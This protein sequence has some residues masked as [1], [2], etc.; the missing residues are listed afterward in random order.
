MKTLNPITMI[1][2]TLALSFL[3]MPIPTLWAEGE[4]TAP[5]APRQP[6]MPQVPV[7]PTQQPPAP[8]LPSAVPGNQP[9]DSLAAPAPIEPVDT[10]SDSAEQSNASAPESAIEEP[11]SEASPEE[12]PDEPVYSDPNPSGIPIPDNAIYIP[13][14]PLAPRGGVIEIPPLAP[15]GYEYLATHLDGNLQPIGWYYVPISPGVDSVD[16]EAVE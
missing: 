12:P 7:P 14:H 5:Q 1:A 10:E 16:S 9:A 4:P 8:P 13:R 2:I 15:E 6:A 3:A 11:E